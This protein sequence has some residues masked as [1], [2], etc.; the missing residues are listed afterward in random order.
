MAVIVAL[1]KVLGAHWNACEPAHSPDLTEPSKWESPPVPEPWWPVIRENMPAYDPGL[2][3]TRAMGVI[4][5]TFSA[6]HIR[7]AHF[8]HLD[9]K[10]LRFARFCPA[11][12]CE[13][14]KQYV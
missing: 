5:E 1:Q 13:S 3:P 14:W 12:W 4:A 9:P 8:V 10:H 7:T 11:S 2:T 6:A